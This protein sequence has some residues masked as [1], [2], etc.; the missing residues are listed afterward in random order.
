M[1]P[2]LEVSVFL[3][4]AEERS[5]LAALSFGALAVLV[6]L[7]VT[8][9]GVYTLR[10]LGRLRD[11]VRRIGGGDYQG[12]VSVSGGTEVSDLAREFNAMA[13]AIEARQRDLVRSERLAAVGKMAAVITHEVRNPLS[14]IGLHTELLEEELGGASD[15]AR[16]LCRAIHGE[17]D[18]L[19]AITEEYLR[20]ARLPRPKLERE[21]VNTIVTGVVD[22]QREDL[23]LRGV[24]VAAR[25]GEDLPTIAADEAQLRQALLNLI[26]NAADAMA[27]GGS[28]DAVDRA[29]RGQR[30]GPRHRHGPRHRAGSRRQDLR[31]FLL[32]QGRRHRPGARADHADR[33]RA[34]RPDPRRVRARARHDVH[35]AP[36]DLRL[37]RDARHHIIRRCSSTATPTARQPRRPSS[38]A[39]LRDRELPGRRPGHPRA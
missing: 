39:A 16:A 36:P 25:L 27:G 7:A 28:L 6:G 23:A 20:F 26:R 35:G 31:P 29:H 2:T 11:G 33:R 1:S 21:Q 22:F 19:T 24:K 13:A 17:V 14:S 34:R 15:E 4:D 18:R 5:R 9:W 38:P 12:R 32:D 30:R 10:P 8:M 3:E 37:D